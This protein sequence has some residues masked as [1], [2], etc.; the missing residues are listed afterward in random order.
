LLLDRRLLFLSG[1]GLL[2]DVHVASERVSRSLSTSSC[3]ILG[4]K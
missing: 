4:S 3:G 2:T 1:L